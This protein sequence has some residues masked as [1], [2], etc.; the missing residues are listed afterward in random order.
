MSQPILYMLL[1]YPGAGKTTTA[2]IIEKLTGAKRLTS[3]VERLKMFPDPQFSQL[4]HTKLY[5]QLDELT[6]KL[7]AGGQSVIYDAN[8]NRYSHRAEKYKICEL[9]NAVPV[10][11]WINTDRKL[12]ETRATDKTR[13]KLWPAGETPKAMFERIA[14]LI[15]TPRANESPLILNGY[16]LSP[17]MVET[18]LNSHRLT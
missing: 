1:G 12:S 9:T 16:D 10:L 4:E 8:L 7:L 15:E 2:K 13:A 18:A 17:S 5:N 14:D 11:I 6:K 3:D